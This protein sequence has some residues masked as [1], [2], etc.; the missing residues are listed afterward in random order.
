MTYY[1]YLLLFTIFWVGLTAG[2][3]LNQR[4]TRWVNDAP[5]GR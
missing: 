1:D 5:E 2:W 3:F 4:V